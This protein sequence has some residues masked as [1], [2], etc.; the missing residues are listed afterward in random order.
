MPRDN[1]IGRCSIEG[2]SAVFIKII[3]GIVAII[4][5]IG[6]IM[7][8]QTGDLDFWLAFG[9][10]MLVLFAGI[11]AL[12]SKK[13]PREEEAASESAPTNES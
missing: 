7:G 11:F 5:I 2:S 3:A 8:A 13:K 6:A 1:V 4:I 10:A 12:E 9:G